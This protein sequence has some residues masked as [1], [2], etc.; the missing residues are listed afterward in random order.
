MLPA[1]VVQYNTKRVEKSPVAELV[2]GLVDISPRTKIKQELGNFGQLG[3]GK[4]TFH[5]KKIN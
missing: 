1:H 3:P 5:L 2:V 4:S